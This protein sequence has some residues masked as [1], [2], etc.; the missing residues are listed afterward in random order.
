MTSL[1]LIAGLIALLIGPIAYRALTRRGELAAA[2][3]GF[4]FVTIG[5]LVLLEALPE[6]VAAGG[7]WA[8]AFLLVGLFG[9]T[10]L[11]RL[12]H[13]AARQ[14]HLITLM[15]GGFGLVLHA[16]A[17][18]AALGAGSAHNP[19]L[20]LAVILHRLPVGLAVWWLLRPS[21]G[22]RTAAAMLALMLVGTVLGFSFGP[23]MVGAVDTTAVAWFQAFVAGSILHVVFNK[24]H[25][26]DD[27][28]VERNTAIPRR[29]EGMG[30]L[31]GIACMAGIASLHIAGEHG[32]A[33][34]SGWDTLLQ[35]ALVSAPALLLGYLLAGLLSV[36]MPGA[37][38][39][40]LSGGNGLS[41]SLRGMAIGLPMPVCSCG[42]LPLY[43]KL[44]EQGAPP[45]AAFAFLIAT[46]ELGLDAIILSLPL[47]GL[48]VT[49]LRVVSAAALAIFVGWLLGRLARPA[50][51][52]KPEDSC[53]TDE[54]D[55]DPALPSWPAR[56]RAGLREGFG[57]LVDTT[58]PWILFGLL[59]AAAA[60][61]LLR[62]PWLAELPDYWQ[63]LAF[64]MLGI[65]TYVCAA[66]ATPIVAVML[67]AGVSPG[68][69]LAFLLAGPATNVATFGLIAGLH[70]RTSA[71]IFAVATV[72]GAVT[73]GVL[74]NVF[75]ADFGG[76]TPP[77]LHSHGASLLQQA[78]LFVLTLVF[79]A[80]I[81]RRGARAFVSEGLRGHHAHA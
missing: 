50:S 26:G 45:A 44:V 15:I 25:L 81:F 18:G 32:G 46:P 20:P 28:A 30:N 24:P 27:F 41:Q 47:L 42:V 53:C 21:F 61:P 59:I 4:I 11:E 23:Q 9:P 8:W 68:A 58:A 13:R 34:W 37:T 56:L 69:A 65:P 29:Y 12:I 78:S 77:D 3:D 6:A 62:T 7:M 75:A 5:A 71:A 60:E 63:V 10:L 79:L 14:T 80:A 54:A 2:L 72:G 17:D 35:L 64:A 74:T 48:D 57:P 43:R 76:I 38:V 36:F 52:A 49:L 66:G 39:R 33:H 22:V 73:L 51:T 19:L 1:A 31:L 70:G 55:D 40:W 67:L 16:T